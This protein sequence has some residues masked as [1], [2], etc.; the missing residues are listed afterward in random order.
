MSWFS[1][2]SIGGKVRLAFGGLFVALAMVGGV[3][4]YQAA[5]LNAASTDLSDNRVPS[6]R[7]LGS[8]A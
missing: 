7:I 6:V 8:L 2:N 5:Q 1:T 3:A 4:L